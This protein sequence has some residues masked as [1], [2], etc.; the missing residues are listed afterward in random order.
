MIVAILQARVS[1]S[2]LPGK[3]VKPILGRPVLSLQLERVQRSTAID[4]IVVATSVERSDDTL[5]ALCSRM[6]IPCFRGSLDDVLD[7]FYQAAIVY[8]PD[9]LVRLTGDCPLID[10]IVIDQV[11]AFYLNVDCDYASNTLEPTFPDGLDVEIFRFSTLE[12]AWEEA[13]LPSQREHVT[14]FIYGHPERF[15]LGSFKGSLDR[16][17]LRWTIDEAEDFELVRQIYEELY[18]QNPNFST[19]DILALVERRPELKTINRH[20]QRNEGYQ[21]SLVKDKVKL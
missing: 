3:V 21:R 6:A 5:E 12:Q 4:Q 1:S 2:R 16:S 13:K 19:E 17:D 14:P 7:R 18:P 8:H 15:R 10:P 11:I 9:H 20:Y